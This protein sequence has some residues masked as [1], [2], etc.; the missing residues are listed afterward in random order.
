MGSRNQGVQLRSVAS[1]K[2]AAFKNVG[3]FEES[4]VRKMGDCTQI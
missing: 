2:E 1:S 4:R 3:S